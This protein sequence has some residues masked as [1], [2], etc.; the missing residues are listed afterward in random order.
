VTPDKAGAAGQQK[1]LRHTRTFPS[2]GV[3]DNRDQPGRFPLM[4]KKM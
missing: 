3:I 1:A 2:P 4:K